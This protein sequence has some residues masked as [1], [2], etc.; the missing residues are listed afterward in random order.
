MY[1]DIYDRPGK[2]DTTCL[3]AP[4]GT[5]LRSGTTTKPSLFKDSLLLQIVCLVT[6]FFDTTWSFEIHDPQQE[7]QGI[8]NFLQSSLAR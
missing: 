5:V 6:G 2:F 3:Q 4:S 7:H 1:S 8:G